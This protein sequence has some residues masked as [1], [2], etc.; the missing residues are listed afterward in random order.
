MGHS[1]RIA[2]CELLPT[3]LTQGRSR[4]VVIGNV[5]RDKQGCQ[6]LKEGVLQA[7]NLP[8]R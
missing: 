4:Q 3:L 2:G 8:K 5:I 1:R 7:Q 6:F